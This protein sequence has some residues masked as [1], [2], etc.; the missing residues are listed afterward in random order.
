MPV[1]VGVDAGGSATRVVAMRDD[2]VLGTVIDGGAQARAHGVEAAADTIARAVGS[3]C[4]AAGADVLF[5]GAAGAGHED[6]AGALRVALESRLPGTRVK[7]TDDAVIAFRAGIPDGDGLLL[8][9]GTGSIAYAEIGGEAHR[10]GGYGFLLGDEGSGSAI[11]AA[12]LRMYLRF[13]DGRV[14]RDELIDALER[15]IHSTNTSDVI[16][17]I[18]LGEH[19]MSALAAYA[20]LVVEL[21]SNGERSAT[22]IVQGAALELFDLI[23]AIVKSSGAKDRELPL[24]FSGGMLSGNSLLTYLVETRVHNEYPN[25]NIVKNAP[26]AEYGALA[27]A[28]ALR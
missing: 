25:I 10:A 17:R 20:P 23:K 2:H 11:G 5:V 18:Y 14:P 1:F 21:A 12:A 19:A 15:A 4:G 3:A 27:L 28:R 7:V 13:C 16:D 9:S 26:S 6:I 8:I 24:T 22:K